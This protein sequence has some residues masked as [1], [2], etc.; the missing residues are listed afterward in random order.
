MAKKREL[1]I[2]IGLLFDI[3]GYQVYF[4]TNIAGAGGKFQIFREVLEVRGYLRVEKE[5][6]W[7]TIKHNENFIDKIVRNFN[8]YEIDYGG[9]TTLKKEKNKLIQERK[10]RVD[11]E[12]RLLDKYISDDLFS[13]W[14]LD[15]KRK[16]QKTKF[17]WLV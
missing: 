1:P 13:S 2:I 9:K 10:F 8:E 16:N 11:S 6:E 7:I 12:H 3:E 5:G 14:G 17:Y 4:E 15:L